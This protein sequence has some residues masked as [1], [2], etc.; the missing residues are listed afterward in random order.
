MAI[1]SRLSAHGGAESDYEIVS[2][3]ALHDDARLAEIVRRLVETLQ[4]E[5]IYLFG[6]RARGEA[7]PDSD[8][9]LLVVVKERTDEGRDMEQ[10]A[11]GAMWGLRAPVDIVVMTA[12]YFEWM[13]DAAA[14][15]PATVQ[16][17][18][19]LLHAA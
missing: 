12:D 18:G 5:R 10:R 9:D 2:E 19:R 16:R 17:E 8:Y 6:S 14:S 15:L 1:S 7:R 4:P 3:L 13:L 11:Y